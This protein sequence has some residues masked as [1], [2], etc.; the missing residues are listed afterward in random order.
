MTDTNSGSGGM[1]SKLINPDTA[2]PKIGLVA[3]QEKKQ[4]ESLKKQTNR[5]V[6]DSPTHSKTYAKIE[7]KNI[8]TKE[9]VLKLKKRRQISAYLS[10]DQLD[11]LKQLYFKLNAGDGE[12]EKSEIVGLAV[13]ILSKL[14]GTQVPKYSSIYQVREYLDT[15]ISKYLSTQVPKNPS[16]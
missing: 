11:T 10:R 16:T 8:I 15:Q 5:S 14:L 6:R 12:I 2:K 3:D 4:K 13:E 7:A 9:K 1:F